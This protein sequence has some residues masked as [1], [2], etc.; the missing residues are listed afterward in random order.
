MRRGISDEG[1]RR[2]AG[3]V[4][5]QVSPDW[6]QGEPVF[7]DDYLYKSLVSAFAD[8]TRYLFTNIIENALRQRGY[9]PGDD[10]L[11][12][13]VV[14]EVSA[15]IEDLVKY[16]ARDVHNVLKSQTELDEAAFIGELK[17]E[18]ESQLD[19]MSNDAYEKYGTVIM[20]IGPVANEATDAVITMMHFY[21]RERGQRL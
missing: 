5:A 21:N 17:A 2:I 13:E 8:A 10:A 18:I 19:L 16:G 6:I 15:Y 9:V 20:N 1:V 4:R 7:P 12:N 3:A 11:E 14:S